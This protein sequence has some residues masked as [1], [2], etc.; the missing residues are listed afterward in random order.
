MRCGEG[1]AS[2]RPAAR[3]AQTVGGT[4]TRLAGDQ[5]MGTGWPMLG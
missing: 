1:V 5:G 3:A 2:G 4:L